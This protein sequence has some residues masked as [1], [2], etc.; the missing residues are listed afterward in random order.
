MWCDGVTSFGMWHGGQWLHHVHLHTPAHFPQSTPLEQEWHSNP[1][2]L[3]LTTEAKKKSQQYLNKLYIYGITSLTQI[4]NEKTLAILTPDKPCI[5]YKHTP[6]L[7]KEVLKQ[8]YIISLPHT[9]TYM[10]TTP[11]TNTTNKYKQP[12][13]PSFPYPRHKN[14]RHNL[15][16]NHCLKLQ[17]GATSHQN[18]LP[19]PMGQPTGHHTPMARGSRGL[20]PWQHLTRTQPRS[21]NLDPHGYSNT[22]KTPNIQKLSKPRLIQRYPIYKT[23]S[24]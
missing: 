9:H 19:M 6:K 7:I 3:N 14:L 8:A 16:Q 20:Q 23:T 22:N 24:K 18:S 11:T 13:R 12:R 5:T 1:T 21:P 10:P 4:L 15:H 2:Y 17:M